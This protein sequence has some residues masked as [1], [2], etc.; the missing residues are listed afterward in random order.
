MFKNKKFK[1]ENL[2]LLKFR[3]DYYREYINKCFSK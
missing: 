3:I 1:N 2:K